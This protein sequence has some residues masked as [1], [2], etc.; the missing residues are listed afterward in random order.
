MRSEPGV[1]G[2]Q[3]RLGRRL[4][5]APYYR[6]VERTDRRVRLES[7]PEANRGPGRRIMAVGL[8]LLALA[9]LVA[10]SGVYAAGTGVGFGAAA[11]GAVV[12]GL[13]GAIGYQRALGGYAVATSYN[14]IVADADEGAVVFTQ[15]NKVARERAQ[16]LPLAEVRALRLRR[17]PLRQRGEQV[18]ALEILAAGDA[19]W[20]VDSAADPEALRPAA[21]ALS[22]A[23]GVEFATT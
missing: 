18:V 1:T 21:E 9:V 10:F 8:G 2:P 12:G 5:R 15:G 19:V 6:V 23:L 17:R 13:L 14:R 3:Q 7:L 22:A 4:G 11:L 20:I 16:R